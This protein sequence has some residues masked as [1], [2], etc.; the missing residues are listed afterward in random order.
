MTGLKIRPSGITLIAI[1]GFCAMIE[2]R[3]LALCSLPRKCM[4]QCRAG[5]VF[6][7]PNI[8]PLGMLNQRESPPRKSTAFTGCGKMLYGREDVSGHGFIRAAKLLKM[9]N[10]ALPKACAQPGEL[11]VSAV[12]RER[13]ARAKPSDEKR[14]AQNKRFS[15]ASLAPGLFESWIWM[16]TGRTKQVFEN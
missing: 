8:A 7:N 14:S 16:I 1:W 3:A 10:S 13:R 12:P 5:L 9:N 4:A 15:A 2:L 6:D 11:F